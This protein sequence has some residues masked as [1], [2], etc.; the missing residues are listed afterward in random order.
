MGNSG[1]RGSG[2]PGNSRYTFGIAAADYNMEIANFSS[3][4]R[5]AYYTGYGVSVYSCVTRGR[6]GRMSGTSMSCPDQAGIAGLILSRMAKLGLRLPETM[7][8]YEQVVRPGVI[9]LGAKG[10]DVEYGFGFIDIWKVLESLGPISPDPEPEPEPE[11]VVN[12][13]YA[14]VA[15]TSDGVK[16]MG[17]DDWAVID[18]ETYE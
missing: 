1:T 18:G 13:L 17:G 8:E 6:Y 10:R 4:G 12:E 2:H 9:D 7:D 15:W 5:S 16:L 14:G 11:P 3:R